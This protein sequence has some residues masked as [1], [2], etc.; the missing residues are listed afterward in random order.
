MPDPELR[1]AAERARH[2][3]SVARSDHQTADLVQQR[4]ARPNLELAPEIVRAA[5]DRDIH[6][7]L[8]VR[9]ANDPAV[10]VRRSERVPWRPAIQAQHSAAAKREVARRRAPHRAEADNDCV[11]AIPWRDH[12]VDS[13]DDLRRAHFGQI[14]KSAIARLTIVGPIC[15]TAAFS[16][17][18]CPRVSSSLCSSG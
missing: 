6:R 7:M 4:L 10:A 5:Q 17:S 11:E 1:G 8:E 13:M 3:L 15:S 14:V 2:E 9:F 16:S 18:R 12:R